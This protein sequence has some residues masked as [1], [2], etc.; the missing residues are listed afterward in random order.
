MRSTADLLYLL[1]KTIELF[2][3]ADEV[4]PV[5]ADGQDGTL[6]TK[7]AKILRNLR[8]PWEPVLAPYLRDTALPAPNSQGHVMQAGPQ[9]LDA[10]AGLVVGD[11]VTNG[12]VAGLD[13]T[14]LTWISDIFGPWGY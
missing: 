8:N 9:A 1:D 2:Y 5:R 10:T 14:D 11:A 3:R 12:P 7:G 4:S 6:F 13:L